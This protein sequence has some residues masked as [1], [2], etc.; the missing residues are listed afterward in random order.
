MF[1]YFLFI[2]TIL[3]SSLAAA[4]G[5][6][7]FVAPDYA[8][9]EAYKH[10]ERTTGDSDNCVKEENARV[11]KGV[12]IMYKNLLADPR[13]NDWNGSFEANRDMLRD[14]YESWLAF[15][16]RLCSLQKVAAKYIE[17]L[18]EPENACILFQN[19][20][21]L[22]YLNQLLYTLNKDSPKNPYP[23]K[24][25]NVDGGNKYLQIDH[26]DQYN[27]CI[28]N[29]NKRA[30]CLKEES[31]RSIKS[32][33]DYMATLMET[34]VTQKWNNGPDIKNG[35]FRD[36]FDSWLAF[37]NR[38]CSLTS[39]VR[40][41]SKAKSA[42]TV[43]TCI[44]F[45]N[46]SF[47]FWLRTVAFNANSVVDGDFSPDNDETEDG[48]EEAGKQ[49]KPLT[50]RIDSKLDAAENSET[51]TEEKNTAPAADTVSA[52]SHQDSRGRALPAWAKKY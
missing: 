17:P 23:S 12:K 3:Y 22:D 28:E 1:K 38:M 50:R 9:D 16:N 18:F 52:P 32:I 24:L 36:M 44:Q 40:K 34:P 41:K 35:N 31:E 4:S 51:N 45:Y 20:N 14:M 13:I 25:S 47:E 11:L 21:H 43:E 29:K 37:R 10:C 49:I 19:Y 33:K 27:T 15:R 6:D 42:V 2:S 5:V 26:D 30:D 8:S 7:D 46:E 48:G 39:Y